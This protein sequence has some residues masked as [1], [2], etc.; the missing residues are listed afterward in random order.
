MQISFTRIRKKLYQLKFPTNLIPNIPLGSFV[1]RKHV[2]IYVYM[3]QKNKMNKVY[4]K[5]QN[6]PKEFRYAEQ[7]PYTCQIVQEFTFVF[8]IVTRFENLSCSGRRNC[9]CGHLGWSES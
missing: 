9:S 4:E 7:Y 1:E 2:Q 3:R 8:F 6:V 5:I